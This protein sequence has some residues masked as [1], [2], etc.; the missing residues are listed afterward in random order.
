MKNE[1]EE[2]GKKIKYLIFGFIFIFYPFIALNY[3][4]YLDYMAIVTGWLLLITGIIILIYFV[5]DVKENILIRL[6]P[7]LG[8]IFMIADSFLIFSVIYP[9][10]LT[11]EIILQTYAAKVFIEGKDPYINSNMYGAFKYIVPNPLYVTPGLNGKLVEILLYPG[12]SVLAFV[13]VVLF[14]LPDYTN[15]SIL[16][17]SE[18]AFH[19]QISEG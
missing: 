7:L 10:A 15:S 16:H 18:S 1:V 2:S 6:L 3:I 5:A 19:L 4:S 14:N 12:M 8:F 13:P 11:D 9:N 17:S